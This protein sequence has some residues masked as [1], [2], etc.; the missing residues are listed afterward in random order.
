[1]FKKEQ[2]LSLFKDI[3]REDIKGL[4]TNLISDGVLD[5]VDY[6]ALIDAIESKFGAIPPEMIAIDNFESVES[7]TALINKAFY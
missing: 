7:I 6:L 4:E 2:T 5:S 3:G 1:M